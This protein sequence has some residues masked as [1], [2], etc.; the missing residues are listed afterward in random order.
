MLTVFSKSQL[1]HARACVKMLNRC[2]DATH[3]W[4]GTELAVV[5]LDNGYLLATESVWRVHMLM[6]CQIDAEARQIYPNLH[7][8]KC[9][10]ALIRQ[11]LTEADAMRRER[12]MSLSF[13]DNNQSMA[14]QALID[15]VADAHKLQATDIH[16]RMIGRDA[17]ISY[18]IHGQLL[19]Q[20]SRSRA[21]VT[22]AIAAA[23]NTQSED[24]R[25]VFDERHI[26][27]ASITLILP[28]SGQSMRIRTQKSPCRD[29][30]SVTLRLQPSEQKEPPNLHKLGF[31]PSR[32][33]SLSDVMKQA[34][35]L[36]IVS[37][38][39]GHGKTTTLAALNQLVPKTRKVI[40]LEDPIEI[41]QPQIEQKFV[42]SDQSPDAFAKMI[43]TVLREDP[44]LVEVSEV[45]DIQTAAA[46]ISAA[47]TGHLVVSTI[48]AND[49]LG[50]VARLHDLGVPLSQL[51]QAE[52]F[53]GL[54][55]QRLLPRLCSNCKQTAKS[56]QWGMHAKKSKVGCEQCDFTGF[57]GRVAVSE[58]V[59]PDPSAFQWIR[60]QDW[61]GWKDSL[62]QEG[63]DSM[64]IEA[65][66]LVHQKQVDPMYAY[67]LVPSFTSG[68][69]IKNVAHV[70][71]EL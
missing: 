43:K 35:G 36:L 34:T 15:I 9:D 65:L 39:T 25:E 11:T 17:K 10:G 16:L 45:R 19:Q 26:S 71:S 61:K 33:Q 14:K 60:N 23:L 20:P 7:W 63:W 32:I 64:A 52:L 5:V 47:L 1:V 66:T 59:K 27:G 44:D 12:S 69:N 2:L 21:S 62:I 30:F 22:E 46:S 55:A 70:A 4:T 3:Q 53:A 68:M 31:A 51:G 42:S 38:P 24:F 67:E 57:S 50:I 56:P 49:A 54:L 58:F 40:S 18:R 48:H 13:G 41:I 8:A 28:E 6:M 29:G 37:G